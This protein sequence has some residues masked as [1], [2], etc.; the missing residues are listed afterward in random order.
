ML[1][2][3]IELSTKPTYSYQHAY[4]DWVEETHN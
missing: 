3:A 1:N 2:V 4:W